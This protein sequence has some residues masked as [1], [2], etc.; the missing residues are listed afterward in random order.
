MPLPRLAAPAALLLAAALSA[1]CGSSST[2][3]SAPVRPTASPAPGHAVAVGPVAKAPASCPTGVPAVVGGRASCL[4]PGQR[5]LDEDSA[6][7]AAY[8][9]L[10]LPEGDHRVLVRK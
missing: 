2:P 7:Y 5:C 3:A 9:F 10:C 6:S 8:G 1:G 4:T